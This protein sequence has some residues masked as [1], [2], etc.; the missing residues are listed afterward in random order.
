M[1]TLLSSFIVLSILGCSSSSNNSETSSSPDT[2]GSALIG[3]WLSNCHEFL[4]TE[5]DLGNNLYV[6]S[7][8]TF[9]ESEAIDSFISYTDINC[10][11]N[12][13]AETSKSSYIIGDNVMTTDGVMATRITQTAIIPDR[14]DLALSFEGIYRI[15]GVDLNFGTYTEGVVPSLR[16][17]VTYTKQ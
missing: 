14:P 5:D 6:V 17:S 2:A 9:S 13:I 7:E 4:G 1:R 12:P 8:T 10:T 15:S 16:F 11:E 3:T